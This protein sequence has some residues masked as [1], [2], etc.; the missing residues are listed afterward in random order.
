MW[1]ES[2]RNDNMEQQPQSQP[3][4]ELRPTEGGLPYNGAIVHYVLLPSQPPELRWCLRDV[5]DIVGIRNTTTMK[6]PKH[7]HTFTASQRNGHSCLTSDTRSIIY[8]A[9]Y[10]EIERHT[11]SAAMLRAA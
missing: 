3:C 2:P 11:C 7:N 8:A 5:A 9:D 4:A 6:L 10:G 1:Y